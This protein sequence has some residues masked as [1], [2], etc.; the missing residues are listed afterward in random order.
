VDRDIKETHE[1]HWRFVKV[2]NHYRLLSRRSGQAA[3]VH[4]ASIEKDAL[5]VQRR[6]TGSADQVWHVRKPDP[7]RVRLPIQLVGQEGSNWCGPASCWMIL[8][9]LGMKV[10]QGDLANAGLNRRDCNKRPLP[11]AC[12]V[13]VHPYDIFNGLKCTFDGRSQRLRASVIA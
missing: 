2:G 9:H 12:N 7:D 13:A 11:K 3:A 5:V 4:D 8:N 6:A 10:S 1:Q